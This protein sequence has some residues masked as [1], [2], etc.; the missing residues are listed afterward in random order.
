MEFDYHGTPI[1][2]HVEHLLSP[3]PIKNRRINHMLLHDDISSL[4][5]MR[6]C[7]PDKPTAT[8]PLVVQELLKEYA[9]V[10]QE[11]KGLPPTRDISHRIPLH[12][13]S[14]SVQIKPYK[15]LHF[16]KI[17]IERLVTKMHHS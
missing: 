1:I 4:C 13:N 5:T 6:V 17:E 2:L 9:A 15:Y 3:N 10:F 12:S 16:Q 8:F 11:P 7:Q 14:K